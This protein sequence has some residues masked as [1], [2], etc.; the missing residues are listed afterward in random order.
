MNWVYFIDISKGFLTFNFVIDIMIKNITRNKILSENYK[1]CNNF[2]SKSIGLMFSRKKNKSLI[3]IFEREK[4][5]PLHM[6]FVFY[7]IDVLFL[8]KNK[9]IVEIKENFRSFTFYSPNNKSKY[10]LEFPSGTIKKSR[11]ELGDEIGF[12]IYF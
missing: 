9:K 6:L 5:V 8:D 11:T 3:F 7:P 4:I 12:W 1:I 10:I 2:I